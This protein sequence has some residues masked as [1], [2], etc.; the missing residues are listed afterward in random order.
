MSERYTGTQYELPPASPLQ[1]L[2]QDLRRL[3]DECTLVLAFQNYIKTEFDI[4]EQE[5]D[6]LCRLLQDEGSLPVSND[7]ELD[8]SP[9]DLKE[10][11]RLGVFTGI[12]PLYR[13]M[14][15]SEE[16]EAWL[17]AALDVVVPP[18]SRHA[19]DVCGAQ[20]S[21][22][23][24]ISCALGACPIKVVAEEARMAAELPDFDSFGY[25]VDSE[26]MCRDNL[27]VLSQIE[28]RQFVTSDEA[29]KLKTQ[30]TSQ[31][32]RVFSAS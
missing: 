30:Y 26:K 2:D 6:T 3:G 17:P 5:A 18:D 23:T 10:E 29:A 8:E 22:P 16:Y 7:F 1:T 12:A 9:V 19:I 28:Q 31:Y 27:I 14:R 13:S 24:P 21:Q 11:Y 32:D 20:D 25:Q 15:T 4:T